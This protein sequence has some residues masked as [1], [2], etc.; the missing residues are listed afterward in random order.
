MNTIDEILTVVPAEDGYG[1][2]IIIGHRRA[3]AGKLAGLYRLPCIVADLT[4]REQMEIML[5]EN[6]QRAD[7]TPVEQ[8]QS[9]RQLV[10]DF[11]ATPEDIAEKTGFSV[12]TVKHRLE[13][14]KLDA[15]K[16]KAAEAK[17]ITIAALEDLEKIKDVGTREKLLD[18]Y[19]TANYFGQMERALHKQTSDERLPAI[20]EQIE[21]AGIKPV[22]KSLEGKLFGTFDYWRGIDPVNA[23]EEDVAEQI[24]HAKENNA[25]GAPIYYQLFT[26]YAEAKSLRIWWTQPKRKEE[27]APKTPE[28]REREALIKERVKALT[29]LTAEAYRRRYAYVQERARQ[30]MTRYDVD[31]MLCAYAALAIRKTVDY[32]GDPKLDTLAGLEGVGT[33][34]NRREARDDLL[35]RLDG[36]NDATARR[37]ELRALY[38]SYNDNENYRYWCSYRGFPEHDENAK[39]D[40]VYDF[41]KMMGYELS[42]DEEKL[43]DG[44]H[45][46]LIDPDELEE[47]DEDGSAEA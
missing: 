3:A 24:R 29:N 18:V 16:L 25:A 5:T 36:V 14:A 23:T 2:T 35:R 20:I 22:P 42:D 32:I 45:E 4:P 1:Y 33:T 34:G 11:G 28:E 6:M 40:A 26:D 17:Q 8:A 43:K 38:A 9:M 27:K 39:L 13:I 41:L 46:L 37:S 7:L 12:R 30:P 15:D 31:A 21:A 44:T 19:G 47:E 10:I